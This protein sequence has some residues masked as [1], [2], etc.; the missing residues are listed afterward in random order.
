MLLD[1]STFC[2]VPIGSE[3]QAYELVGGTFSKSNGRDFLVVWLPNARNEI[4]TIYRPDLGL[5]LRDFA[6]DPTQDLLA[7]LER[8]QGCA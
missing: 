8:D 1:C 4:Q 5:R 2:T 3:C 6:V 7:I